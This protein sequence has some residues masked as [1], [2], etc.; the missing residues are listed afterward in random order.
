MNGAVETARTPANAPTRPNSDKFLLRDESI[1]EEYAA[2][3]KKVV[4]V[5]S[6]IDEAKQ[7][8]SLRWLDE[9][10]TPAE[11]FRAE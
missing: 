9:I 11:Q 1:P 7:N 4:G 8:R 6:Q 5:C 3:E 10:T 2:L